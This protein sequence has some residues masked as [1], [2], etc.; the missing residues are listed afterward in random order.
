VKIE[1]RQEKESDFQIVNHLT[2]LAFQNMEFAD[3]DEHI[4][5]AHLRNSL[6][7]IPELSLVAILNGEIVGHILFTSSRIVSTDR[8]FKSL[9]LA[10]VS[11][12]P[13]YQN[14]GIGSL[15]IKEGLRIAK[16]MGHTNVNVLGHADYYPKFGFFPASQFGVTIPMEVPDEAF[17]MLELVK[18][19]LK[20]IHGTL[21]WAK[22]FGL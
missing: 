21:Q 9:T 11:V 16:E 10:P 17:M 19:S 14:Q 3:G 20:G 4:L 7:F 6:D 15:L 8:V 22:E 1:I 2:F 5:V 18:D 12:H 13:D